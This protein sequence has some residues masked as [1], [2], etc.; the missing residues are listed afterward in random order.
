VSCAVGRKLVDSEGV[1][2]LKHDADGQIAR[3]KERLAAQ[4]VTQEHGVYY[5]ETIA[6]TVRAIS[7]RT[8]LPLA[9]HNDWEVEQLDMVTEFSAADIE[10]ELYMR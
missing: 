9:A 10:E 7:I 3:H 4:G 5:H 2:K 6:P 8:L 1:S